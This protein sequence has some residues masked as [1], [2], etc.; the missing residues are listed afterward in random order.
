MKKILISDNLDPRCVEI[1]KENNIQADLIPGLSKEELLKIIGNYN[2]LIVRSA[3]QVTAEVIEKGTNLEVIGRA[4]TG[5]DNI[6]VNA[7]T[8][9]GILVMN[10]PGGNT[11]SA[12]EHTFALMMSLCRNIPQGDRSMKEGKWERKNLSGCELSEKVVGIIGLGKIGREVAL[13]ALA[14]NMK[15]LGYDPIMSEDAAAKLG[16]KLLSIEELMLESDIITLHVPLNDKTKNLISLETLKKCKKGVKII[17]CARGGV[18]NEDEIVEAID[19]GYVSGAAF[20]VYSEEPPK[21]EKM[22][23]HPKIICTPHLGASTVE[24]QEKVAFQIA[25]Q[26]IDYYNG[27]DFSGAVNSTAVK[28][29]DKTISPFIRLAEVLG[30][31]I[32]QF[33]GKNISD[34]RIIYDGENLKDY[35]KALSVGAVKGILSN[36]IHEPVNTINAL[37]FA[38]EMGLDYKEMINPTSAN[39]NS[40]IT[41]KAKTDSS[42]I[43]VSGTVFNEKEIRITSIDGIKCE[44]IPNG[45]ILFYRNID[46]PG[47]LAQVSKILADYKINIGGLSLARQDNVKE[48]MTAVNVDTEI[49]KEAL[50]LISQIKDVKEVFFVHF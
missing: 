2:G 48:A 44:I 41:I 8:R 36:T 46:K 38:K 26:I 23:K 1:F 27:K 18:V 11:I 15:V 9:K 7:A 25:E 13:R 4:G 30:S 37:F 5:I 16:I 40:E 20:D 47:M 19:G 17:N 21:N 28:T 14:F 42:E 3:T 50:A 45:Y 24:A 34:I 49:P 10:T 22:V 33:S 43:S 29:S 6:D 39:Y 12:A 31:M 35:I 32:S